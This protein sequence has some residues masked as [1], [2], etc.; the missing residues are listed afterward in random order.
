MATDRAARARR[1]V[2]LGGVGG[3]AHSVG[4]IILCRFL[5]RGGYQVRYLGTQNSVRALC[6]AAVG[7]DAVLVSNM[8]GHARHYLRDLPAARRA[9]GTGAPLWY[10]GGNPS[11][12]SDPGELSALRLLGFDRVFGGYVEPRQVIALLD[13]DCGLAGDV[14]GAAPLAG[15]PAER[16][17][18][19]DRPPRPRA[20]VL[21][22]GP[23]RPDERAEVL[24]LW[25]T[26]AAAAD[27]A[28]NAAA[29]ADR[30]SLSGAQATAARQG[31]I[32][33]QPR[34]GVAGTDA[35][36]ELFARL[37]DAGADVL[38]FQIDSLTRNNAYEDVE[39]VL[40]ERAAGPGLPPELNGF[41]MVNHGVAAVR[42]ITGEFRNLPIQVRHS[43]RD[44]R[45]LAEVA[46]AG[47]VTAFEGGA[48]SYNLPYYRDYPP[49]LAVRRWRYVDALAA[50]Y[51]KHAG[52]VVDR[53]FFGVL[54]AS[55][56]PPCVA[57]AVNVLEALLAAGQGVRSVSLGYAEQGHRVQDIAAIRALRRVGRHFLDA[58][59][60]GAVALHTVFHQYMGAFP[61]D[62]GKATE[63]LRGSAVTAALSGATRL[64]LKTYVEAERIPGAAQNADSLALVRAALL[65]PLPAVDRQAVGAEEELIASE[66]SAI[67]A[68]SLRAGG[69]DIAEAVVRGVERGYLDVPFA[70]SLWNAGRALP[71]RD[72]DGAVRLAEPG[73]LPLPEQSR[74]LHRDLV[75]RRLRASGL[76]IEESIETD[77]LRVARGDFERWPLG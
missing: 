30:R 59:G 14:P 3:D 38:S 74:R 53:E 73:G 72:S 28:A 33:V 23:A 55:L 8:D 5:V 26:G 63:L 76:S 39:L 22:P 35:Q 10:L 57:V 16:R 50:A 54:T 67:V 7:A 11:L 62:P 1:L 43:T 48:L 61:A 60:F 52:V 27:M 41:P 17:A 18:A 31:R 40:K 29:M 46:F 20:V 70:P 69:G 45:L 75:N 6:E 4:L 49:A 2:V 21:A 42:A 13:S 12:S 56:V 77:V 51:H 58:S 44:P 65:A 25:C 34:T 64:M 66:A 37:R 15:G 32:L 47:G 9:T 71:V 24:S 19:G 68:A 36:R